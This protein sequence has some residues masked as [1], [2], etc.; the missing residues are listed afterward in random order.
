VLVESLNSAANPTKPSLQLA[1]LLGALSHALDLVEGQ[2]AGH[3]IR[4]CWIG[5]HIG[6]ELGLTE[7]ALWDLYYTLLL[8]DLGCSSNAA[9]ICELYL[10]DDISF[11]ADVKSVDITSPIQALQFVLSHTGLKSGLAKRFSA[12]MNT[13]LR[14]PQ[15]A[16]ELIEAR[17][18][19]GADIARQMRF[20]EA[21]ANGIQNLDEH[22]NGKGQPLGVSGSAIPLN[23]RIALASQVVDVF[24]VISGREA[25]RDELK[26]RSGRWFDPRVVD[27]FERVAARPGFWDMLKSCELEAEVLALEPALHVKTLDEAFLDDIAAGFAQVIDSKSPYTKGHSERVTAYADMIAAEL[28]ISCER[29]RWLKRVALLH[30]I[31]KLGVSNSILDKPGKLSADEWREIYKHPTFTEDV[32]KRIA[33]LA[34]AAPVAAAHHE[35]LDG[36]G[37]PRR[38]GGDEIVLE[39]RILTVADIF[40]ALTA[41]RPYRP[42]MSIKEAIDLMRDMIHT[43]IDKRCFDALVVSLST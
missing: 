16:R 5:I 29:R 19:R 31:G 17:C 33:A 43:A 35:R 12:L 36:L 10:T 37:Y 20:S 3:G 32:L 7:A 27:A 6:R 21:V 18:H 41:D 38:I 14:S 28:G 34:D 39:T 2:P 11:K 8:K 25:A 15:I 26:R 9:R 24:Q 13:C 4:C 23:S 30:D 1:G 42:A 22:W 40:D